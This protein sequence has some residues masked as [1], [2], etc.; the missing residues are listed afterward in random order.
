MQN[1]RLAKTAA[2][3]ETFFRQPQHFRKQKPQSEFTKSVYSIATSEFAQKP[4]TTSNCPEKLEYEQEND[5]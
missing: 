3:N 4:S 2:K 5:V 1:S